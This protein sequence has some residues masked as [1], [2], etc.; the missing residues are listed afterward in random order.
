MT[1]TPSKF[2]NT[3]LTGSLAQ[4]SQHISMSQFI[5][6]RTGQSLIK[7]DQANNDE[8]T[9]AIFEM[10]SCGF[11]TKWSNQSSELY[12]YDQEDIIGLHYSVLFGT[13]ELEKG[14]ASL[15]LRTAQKRGWFSGETWQ[16][17]KNG[18]RFWAYYESEAVAD[19]SGKVCGYVHTVI[20]RVHTE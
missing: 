18:Q 16:M 6:N 7:D 9:T 13:P 11:I 3:N 17:R 12:G 8:A 14:K 19:N 4:N 1:E 2:W 20:E 5:D 10:D 15:S